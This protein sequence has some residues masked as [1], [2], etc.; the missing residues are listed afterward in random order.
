MRIEG[1][2]I[3]EFSGSV[4]GARSATSE[5]SARAGMILR[6]R[7]PDGL[8]GYGEASPLPGYSSDAYAPALEALRTVEW[9]SLPE[10]DASS[11]ANGWVER[12]DAISASIHLPS[13]R[14]ALETAYLDIAGQHT[15]RPIWQLI[16]GLL[17]P[18]SPVPVTSLVGSADD[19]GIV[20]SARSAVARGVAGV[21]LKLAGPSSQERL[22]R[23]RAVRTAIGDAAIRLDAN[24]S[25]P[26]ENVQSE[27]AK[28]R[29]LG[30]E[31]VEEPV[32]S[33]A[34]ASLAEP[35]VAI[36]LD[37]SLQDPSIWSRL[38][39]SLTRSGCVALV[40]KPMALGGFSQCLRWARIARETGLE[41]SLSHLFDGPV[42]LT[43]CAH[44]ALAVGSRRYGSG[45]DPHGA[46]RA[47]PA[48]EL[49][50]HSSSEIGPNVRHGLGMAPLIGVGP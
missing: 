44:L 46:L 8:V 25:L 19:A 5:W 27:L 50:L 16:S 32:P 45:L 39:P 3:F 36:A 43:A 24:G 11:N 17:E 4:T 41:V 7:T 2:D 38:E 20:D 23:V 49:P 1:I 18:P 14:F 35:A 21:K 13:A 10:P 31:F 29:G 9:D 40:L 15:A 6:V 42:A 33:W 30:I 47:W 26:A 12:L 28:F 37:E 48:A 22:A 34:L